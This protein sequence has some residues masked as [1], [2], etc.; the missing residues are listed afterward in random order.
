M[1]RRDEAKMEMEMVTISKTL[2]KLLS[3]FLGEKILLFYAAGPEILSCMGKFLTNRSCN[4]TFGFKL[5]VHAK[6]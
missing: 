5:A 6:N 2:W 3:I 1:S 4:L